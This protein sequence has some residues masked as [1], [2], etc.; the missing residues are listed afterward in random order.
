MN[1][2]R[3]VRELSKKQ[4][5]TLVVMY[6]FRFVTAELLTTYYKLSS[7]EATNRHLA[8]LLTLGHIGRMYSPASR[9]AGVPAY[10]YL[11]PHSFKYV[12]RAHTAYSDTVSKRI[13]NDTKASKEFVL[14]CIEVFRTSQALSHQSDYPLKVFSRSDFVHYSYFPKP[15]PDLYTTYTIADKRHHNFVYVV[16]P[17]KPLFLLLR[18]IKAYIDYREADEWETATGSNAPGCMIVVHSEKEQLK[19][20]RKVE[21]LAYANDAYIDDLDL[22]ITII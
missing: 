9:M 10:Y 11:L 1:K 5:E 2:V 3:I 14:E 17:G 6:K 13:R 20:R 21:Q 19:I 12:A 8:V 15:E 7:T 18:R 4:Q 16:T 22:Q